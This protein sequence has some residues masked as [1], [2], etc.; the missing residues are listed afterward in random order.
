MSVTFDKSISKYIDSE[1]GMM[2][3]VYGWQD[4]GGTSFGFYDPAHGDINSRENWFT[5]SG[6]E[7]HDDTSPEPAPAKRPVIGCRIPALKSALAQ[8]HKGD[9]EKLATAARVVQDCLLAD[10]ARYGVTNP[11]IL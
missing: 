6:F 4:D 5:F 1:T 7:V 8:Y 10:L 9:P 3:G 2:V 11:K